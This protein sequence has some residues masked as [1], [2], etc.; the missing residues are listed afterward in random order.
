MRNF[1]RKL[2]VAVVLAFAMTLVAPAASDAAGPV[3]KCS[4]PSATVQSGRTTVS[5]G[6]NGL[7]HA[8]TTSSSIHLFQCTPATP[9]TGAGTL[10]ITLITAAINCTALTT[11]HVWKPSATIK[12]KSGATSTVPLTV[13][14]TGATRLANV[15]GKITKGLFVGHTV[16]AQ[17]HFKPVISPN[18]H[19][20]ADAC[21][22]KVAPGSAGRISIVGFTVFTTKALKIT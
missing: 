8:Q 5:P 7:A 13:A 19:T 11:A 17:F 10:N 18:G 21:A 16:T 6:I 12:W 20:V 2:S 3:Q 1:N 14:T 4:G 22:N 15:S 9:T